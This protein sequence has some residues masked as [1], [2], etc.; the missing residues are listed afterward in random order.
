MILALT[1]FEVYFLM[2]HNPEFME[3]HFV[4]I[5]D[6]SDFV[7]FVG[8]IAEFTEAEHAFFFQVQAADYNSVKN[9]LKSITRK[10][11]IR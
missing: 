11:S 9:K 1:L 6:K 10:Q 5:I 7:I 8:R 3:L 4:L 2:G